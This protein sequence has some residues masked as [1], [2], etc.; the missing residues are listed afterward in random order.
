M[1]R[2]VQCIVLLVLCCSSLVTAQ[3]T[4][5]FSGTWVVVRIPQW[6]RRYATADLEIE[7]TIKQSNLMVSSTHRIV[8]KSTGKTSGPDLA[9]AILYLDGRERRKTRLDGTVELT[10]THWDGQVLVTT[11][12][13]RAKDGRTTST[14]TR[15]WS[16]GLDGLLV[17]E[18][19]LDDG[20]SQQA[21]RD[22]MT[23]KR[24]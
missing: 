4:P 14:G 1:R 15:K 23:L 10:R 17:V 6:L 20:N 24:K 7:T 19:L 22:I 21:D 18:A 11:V 12:T 16:L 5:D 3:P 9:P 8:S 13:R 2:S